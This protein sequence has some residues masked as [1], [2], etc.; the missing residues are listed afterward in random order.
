MCIP[1]H[2]RSRRDRILLSLAAFALAAGTGLPHLIHSSSALNEDWID[3]LRGLLM[4]VSI[5]M[6]L[7]LIAKKRRRRPAL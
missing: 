3:A 4:G 1:I 5:G 6:N 7:M 2:E